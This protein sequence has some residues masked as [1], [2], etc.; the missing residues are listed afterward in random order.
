MVQRTNF[1]YTV[2]TIEHTFITLQDGTRLAARMWLPDSAEPVPAL[3]EYIPYR[4]NDG[5]AWRDSIRHPYLAGH[6]YAC[7]RIDMRG[8]GDSDGL[9][10]DEYLPQELEDGVEL[11][12]W[13]AAQDWCNGNVGMFGK[14]WGGFNALQIAALRPPALKA[15]ITVCSTDDRYADDVHYMGGALLASEMLPW[16]ATMLCY[17]ASPPDPKNVGHRWREMWLD[18]LNNTPPHVEA[19]LQHQRRDTFW[20]HGSICE[21]YA[22]IECAVYAVGGWADGYTNAIPR[23]MQNLHCPRKGLIGPWAHNYPT[24]SSPQPSIGFMQESLRWWDYWLKQKE[25]GIMAEPMLRS[26]VQESWQ[27]QASR[28]ISQGR[29]VADTAWPPPTQQLQTIQFNKPD[30]QQISIVGSSRA[31]FTNPLWLGFGNSADYPIDQRSEDGLSLCW[32]TEPQSSVDLLGQPRVQLTVSVD[33]PVASLVARLCDIAPSGESTLVSWGLCNLNQHKSQLEPAALPINQPFSVTVALNDCGHQLAQ[34]HRWR[35][36][37]SPTYFPHLWPAPAAV[38]L[39]VHKCAVTLP[40]RAEAAVDQALVAFGEVECSAAIPRIRLHDGK[41][42]RHIVEEREA[43]TL[44]FT[45]VADS[46]SVQFSDGLIFTNSGE[47]MYTLA[48]E[49]AA[50]ASA[51]QAEIVCRRSR[52][53]Q[54]G[55]WHVRVATTSRMTSDSINFYVHNQVQA[56]E[57]TLLIFDKT[58][59]K[60]IVRDFN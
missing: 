40:L 43:G 51:T 2:K 20:Q 53:L 22:D 23:M 55:E 44:T 17:N 11:I 32:T 42:T 28:P 5:T 47:D 1:P 3:L 19:W 25:T 48:V 8:S 33:Q 34:G 39:T 10:L 35:I 45:R 13:L 6:G 31:G 58:Y 12:A 50:S 38:T 29:W 37:V 14:S 36:A 21:D 49:G 30:G 9:L 18:R 27:P 56:F 24:N 46:G 52:T 4:K 7:V 60:T 15:I 54:R 59:T 41:Q 57:N 26:W 16:A